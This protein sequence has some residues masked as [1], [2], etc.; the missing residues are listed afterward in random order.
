MSRKE[1][2]LAAIG[3]V[4]VEPLVYLLAAAAAVV[5]AVSRVFP[6]RAALR[7]CSQSLR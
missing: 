4:G 1:T 2:W 7:R 3:L 6:P 5:V